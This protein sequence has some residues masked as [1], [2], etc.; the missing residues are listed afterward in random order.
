VWDSQNRLVSCNYTAP[1]GVAYSSQFT[2][3]ADG[4][5]RRSVVTSNGVTNVVDT[6]YDA[7]M[8][9]EE[10]GYAQGTNTPYP[11]AIYLIGPRG[12]EYRRDVVHQSVAWY[13]YDGLGSVVEEV[14]PSG[15]ITAARKYDVYGLVRS[16]QAGSS[17]QKYVG[18]LGHESEGNTGL[19]Y[20][21]A[22][23]MDPVLGRFISEDPSRD[24]ANWFVYCG[25]EPVNKIDSSGRLP[26]ANWVSFLSWFLFF[27]VFAAVALWADSWDE[28][29]L[30]TYIKV[31]AGIIAVTS[32]IIAVLSLFW[33]RV[34][35]QDIFEN[36][37]DKIERLEQSIDQEKTSV[38]EG[39][40]TRRL[41]GYLAEEVLAFLETDD[42]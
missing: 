42:V 12:P 34:P 19:I 33:K 30:K 18:S 27:V 8:P 31:G 21:R 22:R 24:G 20:M 40:F 3:G 5:R 25:D 15:N 14:D 41:A 1:N 2:Y 9:V 38:G 4:L 16:G 28:T 37:R 26:L 17:S 10:V 11:S 39:S 6:V 13:V 36:Y 35:G 32:A 23:Y 29:A 7:G